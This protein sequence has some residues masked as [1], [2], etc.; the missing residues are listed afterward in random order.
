MVVPV[1]KYPVEK[2]EQVLNHYAGIGLKDLKTTDV[3]YLEEFGAFYNYTSDAG[4][5]RFVC[6]RGEKEGNIVRL[7]E[8]S[9]LGT[10][11]LVL[12]K[13]GTTYHIVSHQNIGT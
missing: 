5:G 2:I 10:D 3:A 11:M 6:T 1:H 13:N 8:E 4:S 9:D 7:Y 12:R